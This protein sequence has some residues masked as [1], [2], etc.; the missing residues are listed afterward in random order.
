MFFFGIQSVSFTSIFH[1]LALFLNKT[2]S[3]SQFAIQQNLPRFFNPQTTP[4]HNP[5][6]HIQQW[7]SWNVVK[8][9]EATSKAN[10][11]SSC[12]W[13]RPNFCWIDM[14][15]IEFFCKLFVRPERHSQWPQWPLGCCFG[16]GGFSSKRCGF[17]VG[18]L[19]GITFRWCKLASFWVVKN[20]VVKGE[21]SYEVKDQAVH[22]N[23]GGACYTAVLNSGPE[24]SLPELC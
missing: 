16:K 4:P 18:K 24:S 7:L 8:M 23:S 22:S 6:G 21:D 19:M 5:S 9:M 12:G 11:Q 1:Q 2:R 14:I 3:T 20:S 15:W 10:W 13:N 17:L